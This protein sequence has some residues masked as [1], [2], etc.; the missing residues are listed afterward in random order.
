MTNEKL[1]LETLANQTERLADLQYALA[2][3]TALVESRLP[4]L[5]AEQ[6]ATLQSGMEIQKKDAE[7]LKAGAERLRQAVI[8]LSLA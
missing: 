2:G 1:I 7:V 3:L 6:K 5:S 8:M 4:G